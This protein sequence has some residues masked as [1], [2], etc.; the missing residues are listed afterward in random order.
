MADP[1]ILPP[2]PPTRFPHGRHN[3][4]AQELRAR[5]LEVVRLVLE[6]AANLCDEQAREAYKCSRSGESA[7]YDGGCDIANMMASGIRAL[8]VKHG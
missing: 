5:D 6:A 7:Y 1:I 8:E 4:S 2:L 3:L